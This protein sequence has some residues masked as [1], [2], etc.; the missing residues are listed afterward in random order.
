MNGIHCKIEVHLLGVFQCCCLFIWL[1]KSILVGFQKQRNKSD[2]LLTL[3][4]KCMCLIWILTQASGKIFFV[5]IVKRLAARQCL[6]PI[7]G[8]LSC[9]SFS[10]LTLILS[11]SY[12]LPETHCL[13][14]V[15]SL[16][17]RSRYSVVMLSIMV[18]RLHQILSEHL[19]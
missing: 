9:L 8:L 15:K 13:T 4:C 14:W 7:M 12:I 11:K 16:G 10:V 6:Y 3:L 17:G 2:S 19:F 5:P 1:L 18:M